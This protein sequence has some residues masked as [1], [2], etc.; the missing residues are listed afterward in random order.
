ML[1]HLAEI[2]RDLICYPAYLHKMAE[3]IGRMRTAACEQ[4]RAKN[5]EYDR[6]RINHIIDVNGALAELIFADYLNCQGVQ[7]TTTLIDRGSDEFDFHVEGGF[8]VDVKH[9][10]SGELRVNQKAHHKKNK[11]TH[12]V[13]IEPIE[14]YRANY[15]RVDYRVVKKWQVKSAFTPFYSLTI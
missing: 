7:F 12:Y 4:I 3:R 10:S 11:V 8:F 9:V 5:P 1:G 13:F 14:G 15:Y 6:G 2:K